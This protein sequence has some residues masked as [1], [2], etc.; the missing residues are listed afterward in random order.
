MDEKDKLIKEQRAEISELRDKLD[1]MKKLAEIW[2]DWK[3]AI[4]EHPDYDQA[5]LVL[6]RIPEWKNI[7]HLFWE[8]LEWD[9][10][11][12]WIYSEL[13]QKE[14]ARGNTIEI[15]Y[16]KELPDSDTVEELMEVDV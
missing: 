8:I 14:K 11:R 15:V 1:S 16:W 10:K 7:R 4:E 5:F 3:L 6:W 13:M 2:N 9:E 12:G